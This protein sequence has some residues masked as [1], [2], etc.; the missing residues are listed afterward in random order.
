[1]SLMTYMSATRLWCYNGRSW[2]PVLWKNYTL[3]FQIGICLPE[4]RKAPI[5]LKN[6]GLDCY[7]TIFFLKSCD[8]S[9]LEGLCPLHDEFQSLFSYNQTR[10]MSSC[11]NILFIRII[12]RI[13]QQF[14]FWLKKSSMKISLNYS[15]PNEI[16][17]TLAAPGCIRPVRQSVHRVHSSSQ[18]YLV[19]AIEAG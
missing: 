5:V 11:H 15:N 3:H 10:Q 7:T 19:A 17:Q 18:A 4:S 13:V 16:K 12:F 9:D 6:A 1:M 14:F 8:H 2:R